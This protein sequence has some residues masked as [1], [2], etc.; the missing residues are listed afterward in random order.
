MSL[1]QDA[2]PQAMPPAAARRATGALA[3]TRH[4]FAWV[5][6]GHPPDHAADRQRLLPD[7]DLRDDADPRH[8]RAQPDVP[9]R[10]WR[11]GQPDA[12]DHRGFAGYMV[13]VFGVSG[14][15]NI[16]LGWPW[17]LAM[18]MA[19]A[20]ATLFGTLGGALAVRTEGI[21]TIMITLAIGAA[22]YY[23]TNQ[24]WAI[25]NG[26][27]GINT[28]ATPHFWAS[29]GAATFRSTTSSSRLPRCA[30][31]PSTISRARRSAWR[32]RACATIRGAW[33]RSAS[34]SMRTASRPTRSRP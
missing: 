10:L 29:T 33:P 27:T 24:N 8:H 34:T 4:P 3:G 9:G 28:I 21:Y 18:P 31:S 22:F 19:L 32:C 12:A 14:N 30:T 17:W 16:S 13:A 7:R 26:H 20:L 2:A 5:G 1:T 15:A 25:F 6:R 11:H 23:F